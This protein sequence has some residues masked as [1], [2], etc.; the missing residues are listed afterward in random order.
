MISS[1][2]LRLKILP[3]QKI[4]FSI[5]YLFFVLFSNGQYSLLEANTS[6]FQSLV[7]LTK[8]S[9]IETR[10]QAI[11]DLGFSQVPAAVPILIQQLHD[12][13]ELVRS[14]IVQ[15]LTL[16]GKPSIEITKALRV[17]LGD[18]DDQVRQYAI[19]GLSVVGDTSVTP[20]LIEAFN[21]PIISV[22]RS[23]AETIR[24]FGK[25]AIPHLLEALNHE[26]KNIRYWVAWTLDNMILDLDHIED[27]LEIGLKKSLSNESYGVKIWSASALFKIDN[28]YLELIK[29]ILIQGIT[30]ETMEGN[31]SIRK[32]ASV[33]IGELDVLG[34]FAS[35]YLLQTLD[36][37]KYEATPIVKDYKDLSSLNANQLNTFEIRFSFIWTLGK[38]REPSAIATLVD[39]LKDPSYFIRTNSAEAL[40]RIGVQPSYTEHEKVVE[41]LLETLEDEN[42]HWATRSN[43]I[44]ALGEYGDLAEEVIPVLIEFIYDDILAEYAIEAIGKVQAPLAVPHLC[45][46]LESDNYL[47]EEILSALKRINTP[48]SIKFLKEYKYIDY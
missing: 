44:L 18:E 33:V 25:L 3:S 27:N 12:P 42:N 5:V 9:N 6:E 24:S 19:E 34:Q 8:S 31:I 26:N 14:Y 13:D 48:E 37:L 35:P 29:P 43:A 39:L 20:L 41:A 10:C 32:D 23:I 16:I 30:C 22:N 40:Y 46:L 4:R 45:G 17:A 11:Q 2:I 36:E 28:T 47:E 7:N 1:I 38:L 21:D 15:A